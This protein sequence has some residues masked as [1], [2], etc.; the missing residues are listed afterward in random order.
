LTLNPNAAWQS[1]C[2]KLHFENNLKQIKM[3]RFY[4]F[5]S[6]GLLLLTTGNLSAQLHPHVREYENP[7]INGINR[8]PARATSVSYGIKDE[9]IKAQ[10]S[11]SSRYKSLNG[12]WDFFFSPT[13]EGA[14]EGFEMPQFN[15]HNWDKIPV[16]ANWELFGYGTAIYTNIPYPFVPVDPP[17]IPKD[18][19]PTGCYRTTF[20][21]PSQWQN[22]QITLEFGGVSSA[23]YVWLNGRFV[24]YSEDSFL[25][26]EFDITP[27]LVEGDN[28]LA[29]KVHKYSDGSYLE[30]Q[31]HWRLGGIQRDVFITASPKVQLYDFVVRTELDNYYRD[32]ALQIRPVFKVFDQVDYKG[33][34]LQVQ[35]LDPLGKLVLADPLKFDIARQIEERFPPQSEHHFQTITANIKDPLK[36]TAE[37][38]NLYTIIFDLRDAAGQ[39]VEYRSVKTGFRKIEIIDGE[40]FVNG[41]PVILFGVNRHDHNQYSGK[42]VSQEDM[43]KDVELMKQFNFNAVRTSHYPNDPRFLELCD[44]YGLYVIDEANLETHAIGSKLSHDPEWMLAHVERAQRMVLRDKNHPSIIFWSLGNESG[45]GPNHAAMA[46]WIKEYDPTR[47]IHYEGAIQNYESTAADPSWVDMRSRM[48]F[49]IERMIEMANYCQDP[50]PVI[51]C[52]YAHSMGNS[53]GNLFKFR[54][55]MRAH[56]RLIGG[57]IWDWMDQGLVKTAPNGKQYIAYGGDFGDTLIN[58]QNFCLNGLINSDQTPKPATYEAKKVFQP[59]E[60]TAVDLKKGIFRVENMHHVLSTKIYDISWEVTADGERAQ[61]G[62]LNNIVDIPAGG[63]ED[64]FILLP[65]VNIQEG[66]SYFVTIFFSLKEAEAWAPAGHLVAW[67]QFELPWSTPLAGNQLLGNAENLTASQTDEWVEVS[68]QTFSVKVNKETGLISSYIR[69]G[70]EQLLAPLTPNFWRPL[71]DNDRRGA[72]VQDN[73]AEW[74]DAAKKIEVKDI[75]VFKSGNQSVVVKTSLWFPSI[76]SAYNLEYTIMADGQILVEASMV[77]AAGLPDMPRFGMQTRVAS[78]L[79]SWTWFGKGPHE[80]YIDRQK[81]AA[82]G[83]YTVSVK[84][85]FFHYAWP[86][87]SNNR[88]GV[89]W[90]SLQSKDG[91]GL[92]VSADDELSVSA[93]PYTMEEIDKAEH[94]WV[95]EPGDITV[96]IDLIQMGLGGDD[97]WSLNSRPHPEF[98]VPSQN[99]RYR[100]T[101]YF[102]D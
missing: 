34:E 76:R 25:P 100:F 10:R 93:W 46:Q 61:S 69:N 28:I 20:K 7:Q 17:Y 94:T 9:A 16:P 72:M 26:A 66:K 2:L 89:R 31:D 58:D 47:F 88:I 101:L 67:E 56:K 32:A 70:N 40:F 37:T 36:W 74:K 45:H 18:D 51:W 71:T 15:S 30:D 57:F 44:A 81:S 53:T 59:I 75:E 98:R 33:Y 80:N 73:Q 1:S 54:D 83:R 102:G 4:R 24:G 65:K 5:L 97:T 29:V 49:P 19:N 13:A 48:Y 52:E 55:A 23:Y 8:M 79:D 41:R 95:L 35:L 39:T 43:R 77:P 96:N 82:M 87:E 63:H 11:A 12:E 62:K 68:G 78:S 91:H 27:F 22:M 84:D 99:Y 90:F 64:I 14:P 92:K 21:V 42:V 86:Q 3:S 85:D 38:P 6:I 60:V 50:R